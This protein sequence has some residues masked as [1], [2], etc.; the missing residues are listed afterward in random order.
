LREDPDFEPGFRQLI[1]VRE[2]TLID[3]THDAI[4]RTAQAM[5]F[6]PGARRAFITATEEQYGLARVFAVYAETTGNVVEVF[7]D[8]ALAEAWLAEE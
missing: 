5:I 6:A 2:V 4:M 3:L 1:D 8:A 7:R